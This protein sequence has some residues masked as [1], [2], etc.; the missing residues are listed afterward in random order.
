MLF[1]EQN[2]NFLQCFSQRPDVNLTEQC[3]FLFG[4]EGLYKLLDSDENVLQQASQLA[5]CRSALLM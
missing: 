3:W 5:L 4:L 1:K 2:V